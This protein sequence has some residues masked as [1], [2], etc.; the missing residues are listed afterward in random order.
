MTNGLSP[1]KSQI[2]IRTNTDQSSPKRTLKD[3]RVAQIKTIYFQSKWQKSK[4]LF[5]KRLLQENG[6]VVQMSTQESMTQII[7]LK[8]NFK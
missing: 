7:L 2:I 4:E 6:N 5:W 8:W 1:I 3:F